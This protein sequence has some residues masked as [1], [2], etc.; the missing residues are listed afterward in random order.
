MP[1]SSY[2]VLDFNIGSQLLQM[3]CRYLWIEG[4]ISFS[5]QHLG[6]TFWLSCQNTP[7]VYWQI[8]TFS[9]C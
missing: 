3:T 7:F 5:S 9:K 2:V 4:I 8:F 6:V 1:V